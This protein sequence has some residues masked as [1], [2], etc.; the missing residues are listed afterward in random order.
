MK[1]FVNPKCMAVLRKYK[2]QIICISMGFILFFIAK[3]FANTSDSFINNNFVKREGYSAYNK[4]YEVYVDGLLDREVLVKLPVSHRSYSDEEIDE[5]FEKCM[6]VLES[7]ILG[8][9]PSLQEVSDDLNLI[10]SIKE[11]G[12]SVEWISETP[13][14]IDAMGTVNNENLKEAKDAVLKVFLTDRKREAQYL[15]NVRVIPKNYTKEELSIKKFMSKLEAID[16]ENISK[17][18]YTLPDSFEGKKLSYRQE[19]SKDIHIIWIMGIVIAILLYVKDM[20]IF[21]RFVGGLLSAFAL[22]FA[23]FGIVT[24]S[25][26]FIVP[27]VFLFNLNFEF[28]D[29]KLVCRPKEKIDKEIKRANEVR[30]YDPLFSIQSFFGGVQNKLYAVHFADTENMV[31]AFSECD[32]SR[33]LENY[34]DV[35]DMDTLSFYINTYQV[36]DDMQI[37]SVSVNLLLRELKNGKI[38]NRKEFVTMRLEKNKDCKTQAVC[39]P[40]ILKCIK[41][42]ANLSLIEGKTCEFCGN[43]LNLKEHD[44]VITKYHTHYKK[45]ENI[46]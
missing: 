29:D 44:W 27:I 9:N 19:E 46:Q 8:K 15:I 31:N 36:K 20:N 23:G 41:C 37:A 26:F 21:M 22:G 1:S 38:E 32:L 17:E 43:E 12:I 7:A 25:M 14:L 33:Q 30:K 40:S 45:S 3:N 4:S 35:V 10:N 2:I 24:F 18:G 11:Y 13:E 42:G 39:G 28:L 16:K 5:V 6:K 34:K